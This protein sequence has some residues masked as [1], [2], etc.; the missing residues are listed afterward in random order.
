MAAE[1]QVAQ[2]KY[3]AQLERERIALEAAQEAGAIRIQAKVRQRQARKEYE[4]LLWQEQLRKE[5]EERERVASILMQSMFR[6][7]KSR[8]E[9]IITKWAATKIAS[10]ARAA[11]ESS[12]MGAS[13]VH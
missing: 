10:I 6:M 7:K 12:A 8:K 2:L 1:K 3:E 11:V 13:V 5:R 9:F 4:Q